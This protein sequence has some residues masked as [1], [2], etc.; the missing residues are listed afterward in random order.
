MVSPCKYAFL[1]F[2][3]LPNWKDAPSGNVRYR[4]RR[5]KIRLDFSFSVSLQWHQVIDTNNIT[6]I[7]TLVFILIIYNIW[8][9]TLTIQCTN[10][11]QFKSYRFLTYRKCLFYPLFINWNTNNH[12]LR[13]SLDRI[14]YG[15]CSLCTYVKWRWAFSQRFFHRWHQY[16]L[17]RGL[18][19]FNEFPIIVLSGWA[20]KA[21]SNIAI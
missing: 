21:Q 18:Y 20:N 19:I 3:K 16:N 15:T 11:V 17:W 13:L 6:N 9:S 8:F 10:C 12:W 7:Y 4:R 5:D 2:F 1:W 14:K